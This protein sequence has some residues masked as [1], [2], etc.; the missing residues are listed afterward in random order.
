MKKGW[1]IGLV[2]LVV[3]CNVKTAEQRYV[4]Y[5]NDPDNKIIQKIKIGEVQA[6]MK[7]VPV[8]Y[9]DLISREAGGGRKDAGLYYFSA[10]FDKTVGEKPSKEKI[11]YLDF[12]MNKD[13]VMLCGRDSVVPAICQKIENGISGSYEYMLAFEK[14]SGGM[15]EKDFTVFYNDKIFGIGTVAFVYD[16]DDIKKIPKL[17]KDTSE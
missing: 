1:T 13:F 5:I 14:P 17:K 6:T 15:E 16:Q 8:D 3:A 11:L 10:K 4:D 7:L 9:D 12:D 2:C